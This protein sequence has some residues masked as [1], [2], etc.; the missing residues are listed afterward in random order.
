MK[1]KHKV[2]VEAERLKYEFEIKRNITVIQGDSATGKTTLVDLIRTY[3][4]YGNGSGVTLNSDVP[5]VAYS[6]DDKLWK[7][8][9]EAYENSILFFDEDY[10]FIFS[11]EFAEAINGTSN[12]YV[13]ITRRP[14]NNIPYSINE[15]Y[16]IRTTGKYHFP[17]KVYHEFYPLF[18]DY[19]MSERKDYILLVE[20]EKSGY[21]FFCKVSGKVE[22]ISSAGNS[23][24]ASQLEELSKNKP[25]MVIADGAAFGAYIARV[26]AVSKNNSTIGMYFPE[27]F[28]WI[29]LK[30]GI[31]DI[32]DLKAILDHPEEFIESQLYISWERYF[33]DLLEKATNDDRIRRY[34]KRK[35]SE[36]YLEG[37]NRDEILNVLP[38]EL[39][40]Y[41]D[42]DA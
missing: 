15:I 34:D 13:L 32:R 24:I 2:I 17:E 27:S 36:F 28:E 18:R 6:G 19:Q 9:I 22:C 20:D 10:D 40:D 31:I 21:Q 23:G 5:C 33:T 30:S 39:R 29:I 7:A 41:L 42:A 37:K 25:V 8:A 16:G 38:A 1:G 26:M 35:L 4:R 3:G 11:R 14:L 12:Y